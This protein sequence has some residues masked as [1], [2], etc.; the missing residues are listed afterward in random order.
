MVLNSSV[1][2]DIIIICFRC[3]L[4]DHEPNKYR[5]T[6]YWI[7]NTSDDLKIVLGTIYND[8]DFIVVEGDEDIN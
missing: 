3:I 6:S 7:V 1:C 5:Y 2:C 8:Y 4:V